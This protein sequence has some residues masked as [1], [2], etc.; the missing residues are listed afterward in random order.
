MLVRTEANRLLNIFDILQIPVLIVDRG[1]TVAY[2]NGSADGVLGYERADLSG[3]G[4]TD[5]MVLNGGATREG[6]LPPPAAVLLGGENEHPQFEARCRKKNGDEFPARVAIIPWSQDRLDLVVIQDI[7]DQKRLEQRASQRRKELSVFNTFSEILNQEDQTNAIMQRTVEMLVSTLGVKAALIHLKG[8]EADTLHIRAHAGYDSRYLDEL[9]RLRAGEGLSGKV[10]A[11][12]RPLL[13]KQAS[14]DPRVTNINTRATG[15]QS[16]AAVPIS[17]KGVVWGVLSVM[18]R[19]ADYFTSM[20]MQLLATLGSQVGVAIENVGL[21][22]KLQE[23][24]S[25]IELTNELSGIINSSLSIGTLFRIMVAEM[26]KLIAYDR[27]SLLL[28]D[29]K[30]KHLVIFA[31]D[32]DMKTYMP[33]GM[34]A[35]LEGTGAGWVVQ[36]NEPWINADLLREIP[37]PLDEKLRDE[38][39]RA[40]I[41]LPLYQE[42]MLGVFNLDSKVPG[43]YSRRDLDLLLPVAR[44]I[45]VALE[46][47]LLFETIWKEKREWEKTFDAFTDLVWIDDLRQRIVR[48]NQS[49]LKKAG[50]SVS[51]LAGMR[52]S[53]LLKRLKVSSQCLC[54]ETAGTNREAFREVI[55][56]DGSIYHFWSYPLIDDEGQLY[57]ILHYLR[58]VT[59]QKRLEQQ[60]VRTDKLASL[61]TLVAGI[62]HEI[63]NPLGII[64][65]Y[66]EALLSRAENPALLELEAFEDFPEYL[67]T[68]HQEIFRCKETL[69]SLLEFA[70]ETIKEVIL[71]VN[72][73]AK[74]LHCR[75]EQDLNR[76]LP[77][78]YAE[79]GSLRQLFVNI[80]INS[81][82]HTPEGGTIE[83]RT[84]LEQTDGSRGRIEVSIR[85]TGA[86]IPAE[87]IDKIFD[88]FFTTKP[89][90]EGS[91]LG[92][93]ICHKIVEE[94][95]GV[96]EVE[97]NIGQGTTFTINLPTKDNDDTR[98]GSG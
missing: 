37:F 62:A 57:A 32:T 78:I 61:V 95:S 1:R 42:K 5:L 23:K 60:V 14:E 82:Y 72:H 86:G 29:D 21:I 47:A 44:Q 19:R 63:N 12:G 98:S 26:R 48:A 16:I 87:I 20:D 8:P 35:P 6:P 51:A 58:D 11:S 97:S 31:L 46:K 13:V 83:I 66:A 28:Y 89:V 38:G 56:E 33:R 76:D 36:H 54:C 81:L 45:S 94:H 71:L 40:T 91:G 18:S 77:K 34:V 22:G 15:I 65:G 73:R 7:S 24:M 39:I 70:R 90:G 30:A 27:A 68:I 64:A 96:I 84:G 3:R 55:G 69:G 79:A 59:N 75:I 9:Q 74:R 50:L 88:P 2:S 67:D 80:I 10:M 49:V 92:L 4:L 52:C 43:K 41:S 85:D 25:Q 93:A 53:E 17:S